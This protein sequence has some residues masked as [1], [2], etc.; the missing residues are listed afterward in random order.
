MG[1]LFCRRLIQAALK[2][3]FESSAVIPSD[4]RI[5][6]VFRSLRQCGEAVTVS[7]RG[8][9]HP[10]HAPVQRRHHRFAFL[11][12][13]GRPLS[14]TVR[15]L[16]RVLCMLLTPV[17]H[18]S[19]AH[20]WCTGQPACR[21]IFELPSPR[22]TSLPNSSLVS[23]SYRRQSVPLPHTTAPYLRVVVGRRQRRGNT[24]QRRVLHL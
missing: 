1:A 10:V 8:A 6:N 21:S 24:Q 2:T 23:H 22:N 7:S 16:G 5:S 9:A 15:A 11:A 17:T 3:E 14:C 12:L 13:P 20:H 4:S 19:N 18:Q